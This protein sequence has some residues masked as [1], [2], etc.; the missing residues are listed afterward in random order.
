MTTTESQ[1]SVGQAVQAAEPA[2]RPARK[3]R[4]FWVVAGLFLLATC[5]LSL[6][7]FIWTAMSVTKPTNVAFGGR[8]G[9]TLYVTT[10]ESVVRIEGCIPGRP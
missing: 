6:A 9:L 5:V 4:A 2:A 3:R 8:F 10:Q 1:F 7:P